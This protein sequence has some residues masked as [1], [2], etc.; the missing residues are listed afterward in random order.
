MIFVFYQ[1]KMIL[2]T[3]DLI[4]EQVCIFTSATIPENAS[5]QKHNPTE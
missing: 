5:K 3:S 2:E 4:K 1:L